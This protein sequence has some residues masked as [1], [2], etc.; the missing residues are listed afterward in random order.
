MLN[1]SEEV[2]SE[3]LNIHN[4]IYKRVRETIKHLT[5]QRQYR[6]RSIQAVSLFSHLNSV[7]VM[8]HYK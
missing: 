1:Y 7:C 3:A 5:K 6:Y 4:L 2:R 8:F